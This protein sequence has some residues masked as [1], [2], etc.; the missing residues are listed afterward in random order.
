MHDREAMKK[1]KRIRKFTAAE[2]N[3]QENEFIPNQ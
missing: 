3:N 2:E 1:S